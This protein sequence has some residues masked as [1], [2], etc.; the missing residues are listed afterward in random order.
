MVVFQDRQTD[1]KPTRLRG[2]PTSLSTFSLTLTP[3]PNSADDWH[4][5][6]GRPQGRPS[7]A[8]FT[9]QPS[10]EKVR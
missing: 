3:I 4:R 7:V 8:F 10:S 2:R 6:E 1:R 5:A 9:Y